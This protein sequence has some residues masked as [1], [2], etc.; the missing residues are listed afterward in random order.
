MSIKRIKNTNS[1]IKKL[2]SSYVSSS[3]TTASSSGPGSFEIKGFKKSGMNDNGLE[4]DIIAAAAQGGNGSPRS[5]NCSGGSAGGGGAALFRYSTNKFGSIPYNVGASGSPI[6]GGGECCQPAPA[7]SGN[8]TSVFGYSFGNG[9]GGAT[10]AWGKWGNSGEP[11]CYN[12]SGG[13]GGG[14]GSIPADFITQNSNKPS[15]LAFIP[16]SGFNGS[17]GGNGSLSGAPGSYNPQIQPLGPFPI[18]SPGTWQPSGFV[19]FK[20]RR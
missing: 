11:P 18:N 1:D 15:N 9:G 4:V 10:S 12:G 17:P 16:A 13:G 8:P 20:P 2:N 3:P 14:G 6:G 19:A 5:G 7:P